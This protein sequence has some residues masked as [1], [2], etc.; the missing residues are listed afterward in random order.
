MPGHKEDLKNVICLLAIYWYGYMQWKVYRGIS[1]D[2]LFGD[3]ARK[4]NL[5][6]FSVSIITYF[7]R[8]KKK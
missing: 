8:L 2:L 5:E 4:G 7:I 1:G 3:E 6:A